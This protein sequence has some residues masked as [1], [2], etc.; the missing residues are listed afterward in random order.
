MLEKLV[1]FGM[2]LPVNTSAC[3]WGFSQTKL[4]KTNL[5][6]SLNQDTLDNLL[7]TAQHQKI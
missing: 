5:L 6:N 3:E 2:I 4:I 7:L 1:T